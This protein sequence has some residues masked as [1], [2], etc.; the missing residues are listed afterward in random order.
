MLRHRLV[1][2]LMSV[3]L[4]VGACADDELTV[5]GYAEQVG[6]IIDRAAGQGAALYA[7]PEGAV[8]HGDAAALAAYSPADLQVALDAIGEIEMEVAAATAEIEPPED[9][10]ALHDL[11]FDDRF[12][13]ARI[14]LAARAGTAA[15]WEELSATPEMAAYR[16]AVTRD[17]QV[18]YKISEELEAP[19]EHGMFSDTPWMS[20]GLQDVVEQ[21]FNCAVYPD[22]PNDLFRPPSE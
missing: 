19:S 17:K 4:I 7:S 14:A 10:A 16:A 8:L 9:V 12:T 18:C 6:A 22:N 15:T 3:G 2:V 1:V 5:D 21:V 11:M 20:G 13:Q